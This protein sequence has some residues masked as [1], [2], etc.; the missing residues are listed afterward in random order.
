MTTITLGLKE[1]M[2]P[3]DVFLTTLLLKWYLSELLL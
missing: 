2:E 3:Q 1:P